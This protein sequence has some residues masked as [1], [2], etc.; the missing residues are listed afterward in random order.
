M[1]RNRYRSIKLL[2]LI[3]GAVF[4]LGGCS[5]QFV[6]LHPS[7]IVAE[8][9]KN[10]I[11]T[12]WWIMVIVALP[13]FILTGWFAWHYRASNKKANYQPNWDFSWSVDAVIW[14]LPLVAVAILAVLCWKSTHELAPY[15][16][17]ASEKEP[18]EVQVVSFNWKWLFIYPKQHIATVNE[19]VIPAGHPIKFRLTSD[20]VIT[21]FYIPKMG[22][23]IY[24]M[25]GMRTR[26]NL[27]SDK[28]GTFQGV[29]INFSGEG[30][31]EMKFK[32]HSETEADFNKWVASV[33][34]SNKTLD[35]AA[36]KVLKKPTIAN[37]VELYGSI[38]P[39]MFQTILDQYRYNNN[40]RKIA[41]TQPA[42]H[43]SEE[44]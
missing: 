22:S 25:A 36:L 2:L 32:V 8:H 15:K 23:Q 12:A 10:L 34:K 39:G 26:L 18:V 16:P 31:S 14:V 5:S 29:N 1:V 41:S 24:A 7:G 42:G 33:K 13:V 27:I 37:P 6:L 3:V 28:T 38:K 44:L 4:L 17:L 20:T 30:Y 40:D 21:S 19:L 11:L 9:E 35:M 43:A